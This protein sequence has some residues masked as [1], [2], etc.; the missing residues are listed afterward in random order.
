MSS[1]SHATITY[2]SMSSYEVIINEYYGMPMDPLDPYVQL[3]IGAPPSPDYIPE[4]EAPPSPGYP[5]PATVSPT[6]ESPGYITESKP[7]ME[8]G[9]NDGD[10]EKSEGDSIDYPTSEGDNDADDDGDDLSE[11]DADNEDEEESSNS[12]EEEEEHLAP[13]V[14]GPAFE[15]IPEAGIPL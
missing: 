5:L 6:A 14:P 12:E 13:N 4:P 10:D 1:D 3:I 11:D 15:S 8:P 9:E 7:E 2:T